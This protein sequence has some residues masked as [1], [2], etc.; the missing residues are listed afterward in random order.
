MVRRR[1]RLAGGGGE[2]LHTEGTIHDKARL[3]LESRLDNADE[4]GFEGIVIGKRHFKFN[5]IDSNNKKIL[6]KV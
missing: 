1:R 5:G 3:S 6:G 4:G 2:K